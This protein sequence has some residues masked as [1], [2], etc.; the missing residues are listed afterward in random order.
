[1]VETK[2]NWETGA[3]SAKT[4]TPGIIWC[5]RPK[6][7]HS[8]VSGGGGGGEEEEEEKKKR[9]S[10]QML[11]KAYDAHAPTYVRHNVFISN[12]IIIVNETTTKKRMIL[13]TTNFVIMELY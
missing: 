8:V 7:T 1:M 6:P 3:K 10:Q 13:V 9:K 12:T 11:N 4:E 2:Q 5:R